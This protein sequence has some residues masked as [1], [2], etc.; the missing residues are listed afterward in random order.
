M[1][2]ELV[3]PCRFGPLGEPDEDPRQHE[4]AHSPDEKRQEQGH[5][6]HDNESQVR[7]GLRAEP[8]HL[9][10]PAGDDWAPFLRH[11][12]GELGGANLQEFEGLGVVDNLCKTCSNAVD[13]PLKSAD[14][15]A[16]L[17]GQ[18]RVRNTVFLGEWAGFC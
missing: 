8:V 4:S 16:H 3:I 1:V 6:T 17:R 15:C 10:D 7:G 14:K 2:E 5:A 12:W 13:K 18:S 11:E 9:F